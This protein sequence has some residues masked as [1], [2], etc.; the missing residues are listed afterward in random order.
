MRMWNIKT[1]KMCNQHLLGEHVELHMFVGTLNK[2][3]SIEGYIK[4]GLVEVHNI[5]KRHR[6][7]VKEMFKRGFKHNSPLP[8]F[9]Y[10]RAGKVNSKANLTELGKRC[11]ICKK[12]KGGKRQNEPNRTFKARA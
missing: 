4:K 11:K 1:E 7:L 2:N 9:K 3:K 5:R 8:A 6:E 10:Q 12:L